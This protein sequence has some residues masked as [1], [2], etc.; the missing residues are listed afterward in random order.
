MAPWLRA[1]GALPKDPGS[2]RSTHM[3][4]Y[5][6][7]S[8]SRGYN[9][10]TDIHRDRTAVGWCIGSVRKVLA[11][12]AWQSEF[13]LWCSH[14]TGRQDSAKLSPDYMHTSCTHKN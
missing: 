12:Q 9:A 8:S 4:V 5:N 14:K 10:P 7:S 3:A 6:C 2:I 11:P 13:D 1:L